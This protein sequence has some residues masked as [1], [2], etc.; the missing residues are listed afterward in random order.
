MSASSASAAKSSALSVQT[1]SGVAL[2]V[3]LLEPH[4]ARCRVAS[5]SS[6]LGEPARHLLE[7]AVLQQPGEQQVAGL[8]QGDV[9]GIDELALRQQAGD[10]QVE[11]GRRDDEELAGLVELLGGVEPAQVGEE[12]VGDAADSEISVMSSSCLA[13]SDSSRSNGPLEVAQGDRESAGGAASAAAAAT[14]AAAQAT[15]PRKIN[16]LASCRYAWAAG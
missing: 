13:I 9:V 11:Q 14:V 12:L 8:E 10:L 7:R 2:A 16:S 3:L 4:R 1:S 6:V 5:R 15:A